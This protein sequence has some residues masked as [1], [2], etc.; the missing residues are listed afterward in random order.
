MISGL[1][2]NSLQKIPVGWRLAMLS[3]RSQR[4]P[5]G[6]LMPLLLAV[7]EGAAAVVPTL[8]PSTPCI[9]WWHYVSVFHNTTLNLRSRSPFAHFEHIYPLAGGFIYAKEISIYTFLI[10]IP[11]DC[12]LGLFRVRAIRVSFMHDLNSEI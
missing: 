10:F 7:G 8:L 4:S 2:Q 9:H 1:G 5:L 12:T 11:N 6:L 3:L